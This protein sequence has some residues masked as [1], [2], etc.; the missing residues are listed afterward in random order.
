M[1]VH[2]R[3][4]KEMNHDVDHC[5][6]KPKETRSCYLC[7]EI[8][9]IQAKCVR[10]TPRELESNKRPRKT[11]TNPI[12]DRLIAPHRPATKTAPKASPAVEATGPNV[13]AITFLAPAP[14]DS[15]TEQVSSASQTSLDPANVRAQQTAAYSDVD[16]TSDEDTPFDG[17]LSDDSYLSD[18]ERVSLNCDPP[19][20]NESPRPESGDVTMN[21]DDPTDL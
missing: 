5:P 9:H 13:S 4:C 11:A 1:G 17:Q 12:E 16:T 18:E 21:G 2:C 10:Q 6:N 3:Y 7:G 20:H 19:S 15:N 8:G 14:F